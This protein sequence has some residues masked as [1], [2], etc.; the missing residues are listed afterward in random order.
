MSP[1]ALR[2]TGAR[3]QSSPR[4]S[5]NI[6]W[7]HSSSPSAWEKAR[8]SLARVDVTLLLSLADRQESIDTFVLL[9][10]DGTR[11]AHRMIQAPWTVSCR[12]SNLPTGL[13]STPPASDAAM[14][15]ISLLL[16]LWS[17]NGWLAVLLRWEINLLRQLISWTVAF[18]NRLAR[19]LTIPAASGRVWCATQFTLYSMDLK[20]SNSSCESSLARSL[21][22]P[23]A[24]LTECSFSR[25]YFSWCM[26]TLSGLTETWR[27]AKSAVPSSHLPKINLALRAACRV[28]RYSGVAATFKSS[29]SM[30]I[31]ATILPRTL[32]TDQHGSKSDFSKP[33]PW[34]KLMRVRCHLKGESSKP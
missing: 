22:R 26:M 19:M 24:S 18:F 27:P 21:S 11:S 28:S 31:W 10:A 12:L 17:T 23:L 15:T 6:T 5:M 14:N 16:N 33:R 34:K 8:A 7:S 25:M 1:W 9:E 29:T 30:R 4:M 13:P 2:W 32:F 3:T 20:S